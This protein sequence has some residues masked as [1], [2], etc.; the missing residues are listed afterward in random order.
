MFAI[1][2]VIAGL[3]SLVL[4]T[5]VLVGGAST[6]DSKW[7]FISF[8]SSVG[9]WALGVGIF[10][11]TD[12][13]DIAIYA[14]YV[15]YIAALFIAYALMMFCVSYGAKKV[16]RWLMW[17]SLTP[18]LLVSIM[19]YP[20]GALVAGIN[21]TKHTVD[22][23]GIAY[24]VYAAVFVMYTVIALGLLWYRSGHSKK[25]YQ[26]RLLAISL[27]VCLLG[28]GY[29]NLLLPGLGVYQ[30][31]TFGPLFTF[32]MVATVFYTIARH[33]LFDIRFAV[34]RTVTYVLS[35][36]TLA[37]LYLLVALFLMGQ[38]ANQELSGGQ[39]A[40]NLVLVLVLAFLFQ[41]IKN[42]F[43][44]ITNKLFYKDNYSMSDFI[45]R[46]NRTLNSANDLRLLL[47]R[48]ASV[49]E[50]TL[51]ADQVFSLVYLE[52]SRYVTAGTDNHSKVSVKEFD[53]FFDTLKGQTEVIMASELEP[54][55]PRYRMM[56]SHKLQ[57]VMPLYK[58]GIL[59]GFL[60]LGD[61][62]TMGYT[63]R[64]IRSL[65][66][67]SDELTIAIQNALS[68]DEV[69]KL[70]DTL[71]QRVGSATKELRASNA[72]LQRLDESKDE[73]I[74]MASHQLRTPLTSIKGYVSMLLEGDVGAV[75]EDQK[76]LLNEVFI[77]SERMVRLIGDFLNVS[78]LQTGKFVIEKHPID[79]ALLVQREIDGLAQ[80]S[81]TR[82]VKFIY[83]KPKNIPILEL[84]ENKIQQ[85]VMNF[86]D[87]AMYYSKEKS[88]IT[89]TLKKI[90]GYV[91]F[92]VIDTG[93]GVPENEQAHLFN[94]FFRA[95]NARRA[96]P[97]GTGV[98]LFLAKKVIDEHGGK[99]LFES[100]EGKGSTFGFLIPL[101][102][103]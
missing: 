58:N 7:P 31:V 92:K 44:K 36:M 39:Q 40:A 72:Q 77:S 90:P 100:K 6:K 97:D 51:K 56:A 99:I 37:G 62:K 102:K 11:L 54:S 53:V 63:M 52:D 16:S 82:G 38:L 4:A 41:P 55:E 35:L 46:L 69:R 43:D 34:V 73:F 22:L 70:N 86:S 21:V 25:A 83:K 67:I 60:C 28:G 27:T 71:E 64:D 96:R 17:L 74:S 68:V 81:S 88:R 50:S 91:E 94:K 30:Y 49:I 23:V 84:D 33:G 57:L 65:L 12:N 59:V 29:F 15:Y 10:S 9:V 14:V 78:R 87:N 95:T 75:S 93:I 103:E 89:V 26:Y 98:G 42:F 80:N 8:A 18:W 32:V 24:L 76:H 20:F 2:T 101:P 19:I 45:A 47:E 5:M 13:E 48:T 79:L 1:L 85:V 61:H 66:T 3:I